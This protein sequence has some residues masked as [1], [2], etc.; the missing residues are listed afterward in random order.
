[1]ATP[2]N[3]KCRCSCVDTN[4]S[5]NKL[6][7]IG[8]NADISRPEKVHFNLCTCDKKKV[9]S[10]IP[11]VKNDNS[12][13]HELN[14]SRNGTEEFT[15]ADIAAPKANSD[16][17]SYDNLDHVVLKERLRMLRERCDSKFLLT[18]IPCIL[19]HCAKVMFI[20]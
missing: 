13:D 7:Q 16:D 19:P 3:G 20:L 6:T 17:I 12:G 9:L 18:T 5:L 10:S 11:E 14:L 1:M 4:I 2:E 8:G 15:L